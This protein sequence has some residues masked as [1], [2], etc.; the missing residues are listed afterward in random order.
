MPAAKVSQYPAT[1]RSNHRSDPINSADSGK[2][3][4]KFVSRI[5]IGGNRPG[6]HNSS[7]SGNSLYKT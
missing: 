7:G 1:Y 2:H 5:F 4:R 6:Y 3:P